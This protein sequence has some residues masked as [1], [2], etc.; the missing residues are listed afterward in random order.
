[1]KD[2][3]EKVKLTKNERKK[4]MAYHAKLKIDFEQC[5]AKLK[6]SA[7]KGVEYMVCPT[8]EKVVKTYLEYKHTGK[9]N[10]KQV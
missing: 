1:M 3:D 6:D 7:V 4:L 2:K 8:F 5:V 9:I 10:G